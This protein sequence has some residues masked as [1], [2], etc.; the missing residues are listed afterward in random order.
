MENGQN[1]LVLAMMLRNDPPSYGSQLAA[2][3]T[4]LTE[5]WDAN[6]KSSQDHF[7]LGAAE[8]WFYRGLGGID[9]DLSRENDDR[10]TLRPHVLKNIDWVK[11]SYDSKL[12]LIRSSW[13]RDG[14]TITI[15]VT[16]PANTVATVWI[17][18]ANDKTLVSGDGLPEVKTLQKTS[19]SIA[20]RIT[21][22]NY[23]FVMQQQ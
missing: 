13:R 6:P 14:S 17:P 22:G 1:D 16:V 3:A 9:F 23:R 20:Y 19:D 15:D 8:E 2:G 4:S 18:L 10:I 11:C 7:M 5:A 21:S 12:G